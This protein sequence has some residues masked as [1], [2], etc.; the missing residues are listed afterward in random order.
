MEIVGVGVDES[1]GSADE[2]TAGEGEAARVEGEC[3]VVDFDGEL[4]AVFRFD[5]Y[6]AAVIRGV[7]PPLLVAEMAEVAEEVEMESH[8]GFCLTSSQLLHE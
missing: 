1:D 4:P 5:N 7:A 6:S 8:V 3:G 2:V